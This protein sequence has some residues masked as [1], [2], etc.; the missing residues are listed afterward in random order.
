[1]RKTRRP[2]ALAALL[3][4]LACSVSA[5]AQETTATITGQVVDSDGAAVPDADITLTNVRTREERKTKSGDDGYYSL[6]F[7]PPGLYDLSVRAQGFKE[8]QNKAIELFVNDR[9]AINIA[10]AA[11]AI[12]EAVTVTAEAPIVQ[13]SPTVGDVVEERKIVEIPLNNRNFLQLVTLVPGVTTDDT[14][15]SGI[16]LTSTTNIVIGG[17]RRNSTNY[18]VD[19]VSNVDVGSNITLLSTPTVDSIQEFRVIT[20][21]PTAEFGRASGGVVNV[22]TRGGGREFHGSLY[23]F[24]RN[25]KLNANSF[26]NNAAGRFCDDGS[27]AP[28]GE[29]CGDLRAPRPTLRYNNFGYTFSGPVWIPGIYPRGGDKTF[30]FWSQ[31][32][33]RII[34]QPTENFVTVPSLRE[35]RGDF[36]Q[37][38]T[39]VIDP[40]TGQRFPGNIIPENRIDPTARALLNFFPEPTIAAATAGLDPNRILAVAPI[41]NNTRQETI[42]IDHNLSANH[43]LLGRY[44]H[45]LSDTREQGGLFVNLSLPGM[46]TTDTSVPGQVLAISLTS[47]FGANVVNEVTFT[48]SGN[49]ITT[50]LIGRW[51]AENVSIP[52]NE[53][54]P[55]NISNIPANIAITGFIYSTAIGATLGANQLF[56]IKYKNVNPKWNLTW[57][58]GA[59]TMKFG[60]DMSWERKDENA[61]NLT[62]GTFSFTGL[63]TRRAGVASGLGLADFLL[64]RASAYS[65]A[66]RD[67]TNHL[68]F[69]R[70]EFYAQDTWKARPNLQIDYGLR[71]QLFRLPT[72]TED[73]LT[74]FL[75]QLYN[76]AF[77]LQCANLTCTS[78]VRGSGDPQNGIIVGAVNSP[79]G[80]RVQ[81]LDKNNFGPRLGF[82]WSPEGSGF[83]GRLTGGPQRT[84]IRGGYGIYYDQVLIGI[85]EQNTFVNP[86]FNNTASLTGTVAAPITYENPSAG[87]PP[88][89]LAA[90]SLIT[91]TDPF[92]TPI[93]QQ[94]N[95]TIQRQVG[96]AV[97]FE[98]GYLGSA[99]NH[100]TRPVDINA[101]TPEEILAASQG[102]AGCDPALNAANNPNNCINRARPFRGYTTITDRQTTATFRYHALISALKVQRTRGLSAQLS[103]TWSKNLTDASNDRDAIDLPQIRTNFGIERAVARFDRT[104]VFKASYV[105]EVPYPKGGFFATPVM[106]H[107]LGGWEVA[108]I[109]TAMTGLPLNRVVQATGPGPRGTRPDQVGDPFANVPTGVSRI[110]YYINPLA[111]LPTAVGEIGNSGRAPF[112]FENV[113]ETDLNIAKNWRWAERYRVQL[114]AE[115]FNVFNKTTVND[116]F[117][118]V[119]NLLPT[120]PAFA[121]VEA[122]Q[123]SGSNPQFGQVFSTRRP[124]EIQIGLKFN[125]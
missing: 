37:S 93:T 3:L 68:R 9:K 23:E 6:T 4:L 86:P 16:G 62:Q 35:R 51:N 21:V 98:I 89:T 39:Q 106:G 59:H 77:A 20:S 91:T 69:G 49:E 10:L 50:D 38:T 97:A 88:G 84:V 114:R 47:S 48:M 96:N 123:R 92:I 14:A 100:Q 1:M 87:S 43:R 82:A 85:L 81:D 104:H 25:D 120:D 108:G 13:T 11:G 56:D 118:T 41:L 2:L 75:P 53:L 94:W 24:L 22:I 33:R 72:D 111:F 107:I 122:L 71:Y 36:S 60:A 19:G 101:P 74:A 42:R 65:E 63:Q 54:F 102:I 57:N 15:E 44:T 29:V 30:F 78:F 8:F 110:P 7:I 76:P 113:Y 105:Y 18:L 34:R 40:V 109:T 119:P 116:I 80:R 31:E 73:V 99:G 52:N 55:Q 67:V 5:V 58:R 32:W 117:Q 103:Y 124:R 61:A 66:E 125:F 28:I 64:G 83:I 112:R 115:F 79:F 26:L 12:E 90:R 17:N 46:A 95:L 70:T 27:A 121:S 45:D